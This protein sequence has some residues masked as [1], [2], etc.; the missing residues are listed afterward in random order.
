M[1][2]YFYDSGLPFDRTLAR[3]LDQ[4]KERLRIGKAVLIP[5]DGNIGEGKSTLG[6]HISDYMNGAYIYDSVADHYNIDKSK[7]IDL[8]RQYSM[9]GQA[10]QE[11]LQMC[12]D[13]QLG[14]LFYD[15]AGDFN[16]RG[17]LTAFNQQ[18]NR[19]FE[20]YR[21]FRIPVI[22][23]LPSASVLDKD[24][25]IKGIPRLCMHVENRTLTSGQYKGYSLYKMMYV[26]DKM[27]KLIV[28]QQAYGK[29]YPL[30]YGHFLDLT[31]ERS[32]ELAKICD[33]GKRKILT[34]NILKN[35]GLVSLPEMAKNLNITRQYASYIIRKINAK[36]DSVL[37][38][39]RYYSPDVVAQVSAHLHKRR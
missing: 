20:T 5:I 12:I 11:C 16:K 15:E 26:L 22:I 13:S 3:N 38:R 18:L 4:M 7:L 1:P 32:R 2:R 19:V 28:P 30:F 24:L 17:S 36:E 10:F 6:V 21:T 14:S 23:A 33:E 9:G 39:I 35:K 27:K 34:E 29:T 37:K 25:F 8:R 31:P